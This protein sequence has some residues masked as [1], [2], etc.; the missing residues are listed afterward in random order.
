MV[1]KAIKKGAKVQGIIKAGHHG[2]LKNPLANGHK[3]Q[4]PWGN[5]KALHGKKSKKH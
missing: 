5:L 2:N 1:V 4:N 3:T